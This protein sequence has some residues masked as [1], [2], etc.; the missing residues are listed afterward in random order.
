MLVRTSY[1]N[2]VMDDNIE[3]AEK[4]PEFLGKLPIGARRLWGASRMVVGK[5]HRG[6]TVLEA[7]FDDLP[8]K[9]RRPVDTSFL[10]LL[11]GDQAVSAVQ[12]EHTEDFLP[13]RAQHGGKESGRAFS[14][15][16]GLLTYPAAGLVGFKKTR[17]KGNEYRGML[18][19]TVDSL[20]SLGRGIQHRG[21]IAEL[22]E[23][24]LGDGFDISSRNGIGEQ[25]LKDLMVVKSL[26]PAAQKP[27][28]QSA[29]VAFRTRVSVI[30]G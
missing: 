2:V 20:Q 15:I 24:F 8:G 12:G 18:P 28:A 10:N 17:H 7:R 14:G 1:D 29:P 11:Y 23:E 30:A 9:N 16:E 27:F 4:L 22:V 13:R 6:R 19:D 3:I 26:Q 21:Q 25:K 5:N